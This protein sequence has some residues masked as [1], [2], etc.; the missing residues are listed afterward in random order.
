[1][2]KKE[3]KRKVKIYFASIEATAN[4]FICR[5]VFVF[6]FPMVGLWYVAQAD[7]ILSLKQ[8]SCLSFLRSWNYQYMPLHLNETANSLKKSI[9]M[10]L[11]FGGYITSRRSKSIL[12]LH[13]L[14]KDNEEFMPKRDFKF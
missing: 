9:I 10:K 4:V 8:L 1:M 11:S 13:I 7:L 2:E 6:F 12:S 3:R 14:T 5:F